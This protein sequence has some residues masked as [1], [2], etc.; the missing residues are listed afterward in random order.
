MFTNTFLVTVIG[1]FLCVFL[2]LPGIQETSLQ[3]TSENKST[4][5]R[6][7]NDP[8]E[9]SQSTGPKFPVFQINTASAVSSHTAPQ[10]P[11]TGEQNYARD[12]ITA[13][14][15]S[16][17]DKS[18]SVLIG[19]ARPI[20]QSGTS[21][22]QKPSTPS[23]LPTF[24]PSMSKKTS[25]TANLNIKGSVPTNSTIES[26][27]PLPTPMKTGTLQ[28]RKNRDAQL[29][30]S[31]ATA[32]AFPG[33]V[34]QFDVA[35]KSN[36]GEKESSS[37]AFSMLPTSSSPIFSFSTASPS[38]LSTLS[39]TFSS[40][41]MP[42]GESLTTSKA[43][44][45]VKPIV[46]STSMT[47]PSTLS[48]VSPSSVSAS[49]SMTFSSSS[50]FP[51]QA[52]KTPVPLSDTP[53]VNLTSESPKQESQLST[54]KLISKAEGSTTMQTRPLQ[55]GPCVA[56]SGS[57]PETSV[58][59]ATAVETPTSVSSASSVE[60]PTSLASGSKPNFTSA[61]G[62]VFSVTSNAQREQSHTSNTLFASSIPTSAST[63]G[64]KNESLD[65]AVSQEDEMEEEAPETSQMTE[66]SLGSLGGF[67]IGSSPNPDP[68]KSNPFGGAFGNAA[69]SPV[70]SPFSMTVPSGQLFRPASISFQ[71]PHSSQPS[72]PTAFSSFSGGLGTGSTPQAPAQTGFGQPAQIGS[73][74]QALG[75]VLG[76][77]GQSR[78][79][80]AGLPGVGFA[81]AS[82]F[83]GGFAAPSPTG[84]FAAVASGS[85]GFANLASGGGGFGGVASG[86]GGFSGV[87]SGGGFG[88]MAAASGGGGFAAA[89][90][91]RGGFAAAGNSFS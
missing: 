21:V 12:D 68:P 64:A 32:S 60:T 28:S 9:P 40:S 53:P 78:Q 13:D 43:S 3:Q 44:I 45:D 25:E 65:I 86:G 62:N 71:S 37:S 8:V 14:K 33:K 80:G 73:G 19:E 39:S 18:V 72:Q 23:V 49:S 84:G 66:L 70:S 82:S 81:S 74:Q 22:N 2:S 34:A 30:T 61:A 52:P 4:L 58:S 50:F 47:L 76:S 46:S 15:S 59:S 85:G 35:T 57:K 91:G 6:W 83:G 31:A 27:R 36:P 79:I 67:G 77:F 87:A 17:V 26:E 69:T 51:V 7:A 54:D 29:S 38:T 90:S 11:L 24:A 63:T 75:S 41:V 89:A 48:I 20:L 55:S 5:F 88:G 16:C 1:C 56:V 42:F 10:L